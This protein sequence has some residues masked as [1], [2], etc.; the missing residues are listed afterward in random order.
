MTTHQYFYFI[1]RL[2]LFSLLFSSCYNYDWEAKHETS[3][4]PFSITTPDLQQTIAVNYADSASTFG[5]ETRLEWEKSS[6]ADF[7]KVFY[8]VWF[9][10]PKNLETPFLK[11]ITGSGQTENFLILNEKELNIV[12]EKAGIAPNSTGEVRWKVNAANGINNQFSNNEKTLTITRPAG[13]A[14]YPEKMMTAGAALGDKRIEMK[15]IA[16][17]D[18]DRE[19]YT[20]EYELFVYLAEGNFYLTEQGTDRRFYISEN[21]NLKEVFDE[22]KQSLLNSPITTGKIH[23]LKIN[24]KTATA[25]FVAI[26]AVDLWYSGT[27]NIL[28]ALQQSDPQVPYWTVT[29][30]IELAGEGTATDYR[31]KFRLTQKNTTGEQS[32]S[33]WG[34]S[35]ITAPNQSAT[36]QPSYFYLY[37]VDNSRSDYCYKFNRTDHNRNTLK[38]DVDFR[39]EIEHFTHQLRVKN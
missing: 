8:E 28:G 22:E 12:A 11:Q 25:L 30:Y 29:Q 39:P 31:Y 16:I 26:E 6:A 33:F 37:E 23:R 36:S 35:A 3:L 13:F 4:A 24:L 10:N 17:K 18:K 1:K 20:G 5:K 7:S 14:Y 9:Y 19:A 38:I 34:Y 15:R 27:N 32:A 21:G 2:F